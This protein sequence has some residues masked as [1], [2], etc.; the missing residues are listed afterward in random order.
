LSGPAYSCWSAGVHPSSA[1]QGKPRRI[2]T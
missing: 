1:C 2:A